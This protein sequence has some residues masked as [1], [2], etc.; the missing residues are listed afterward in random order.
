MCTF[1][2]QR[3]AFSRL[4]RCYPLPDL[5]QLLTIMGC[6]GAGVAI[7]F[8]VRVKVDVAIEVCVGVARMTPIQT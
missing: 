7:P 8:P 2:P 6:I 1:P 3:D 5:L 4:P